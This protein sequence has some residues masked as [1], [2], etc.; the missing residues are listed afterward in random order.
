MG[1]AFHS[2]CA[3]V[4]FPS[5][6]SSSPSGQFIFPSCFN[7]CVTSSRAIASC[8]F[9]LSVVN[10]FWLETEWELGHHRQCTWKFMPL[11]SQ[12][13]IHPHIMWCVSFLFCLLTHFL[14]SDLSLLLSFSLGTPV[15][16]VTPPI[17]QEKRWQQKRKDFHY[18]HKR[19]QIIILWW[20]TRR[21]GQDNHGAADIFLSERTL[22]VTPVSKHVL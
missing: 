15:V 12:Y 16:T 13:S 17:Q 10:M 11:V 7:I 6:V 4:I 5:P 14:K 19:V 20:E 22:P 1:L 8:Q 2:V 21:S 9:D 18:F 3:D